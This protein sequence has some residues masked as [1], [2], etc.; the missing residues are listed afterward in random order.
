MGSALRRFLALLIVVYGL[1]GFVAAIVVFYAGSTGI[2]QAR[3]AAAS[4]PV[5]LRRT[6]EQLQSLSHTVGDAGA[7]TGNFRTSLSRAETSV[8]TASTATLE[9][10]TALQALGQAMNIDILGSRPLANVAVPLI[11]SGSDFN[12]LSTDLTATAEALSAN[13]DDLSRI[14]EDLRA[15]ERQVDGI[16]QGLGA[17]QLSTSF[18]SGFRALEAGLLAVSAWFGLQGLLFIGLGMAL[19]GLRTD[20]RP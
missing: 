14:Q 6:V 7:A 9:L 12:T 10:S 13:Q 19:F 17:V 2:Q 18:E 3:T 4:D 11:E 1:L 16:A 8:T 5:A 20:A 15:L